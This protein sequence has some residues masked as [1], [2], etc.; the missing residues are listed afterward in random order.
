MANRRCN[1]DEALTPTR[2]AMTALD[3]QLTQPLRPDWIVVGENRVPV[4]LFDNF[5]A[6]AS[7]IQQH[8]YV[9]ANFA[10]DGK[11]AYPGLR[12]ALP[13]EYVDLVVSAIVP[14][15][16]ETYGIPAYYKPTVVIASYSLLTKLESELDVLQRIPH[17]DSRKPFY[18]ALLHFLNAGG[19]GGTAFYRHRPTGLERVSDSTVMH[20]IRSAESYM[21]Q[22]GVPAPKYI[23]G[24]NDHYELIGEVSY[25]A[26]RLVA[27][28]GNLLHSTS[29][30]PARDISADPV[31]GRLTANIFLNFE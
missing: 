25:S 17:F 21:Q 9:Q 28:P 6:D 14:A 18:F 29:V 20:Y 27:Y 31:V 16:R 30:D 11:T 5:L 1:S 3:I 8:A 13:A 19:H 7:G 10:P 22:T 26:N 24:S 12:S 15:L 23:R 4:L 2:Y